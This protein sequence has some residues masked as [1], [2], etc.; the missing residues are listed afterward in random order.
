MQHSLFVANDDL[1]CVQIDQFAQT[2]VA[3]VDLIGADAVALGSD[4]DGTVTTSLDTSELAAITQQLLDQGLP[5][6]AIRK[7]MG[8]NVKRFLTENL[9][10]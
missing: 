6:S 2:I 4:F 3:A 8:G 7:V 10:E 5:E 9:P 1:R